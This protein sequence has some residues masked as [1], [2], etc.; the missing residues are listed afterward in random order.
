MRKSAK[1]A[2]LGLASAGFVAS[3]AIGGEEVMPENEKGFFD[4]IKS[5]IEVMSNEHEYTLAGHSSH[6]SH[7]SH[8]SHS[9]HRSY[10]A[11]PDIYKPD[12]VANAS[13][14]GVILASARNDRSTPNKSVLPS[15]LKSSKKLKVLPG[16]SEKFSKIVTEA[17]LALLA[18]GYDVG[19]IDGKLDAMAMSSIYKFQR[20][21]GMSATGRLTPETLDAL[22]VS[23]I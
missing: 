11:P 21:S 2:I 4:Q 23:A 17:Q 19:S 8:G 13:S 5:L 20:D 7:G 1:F 18:K 12:E 9:S 14:T 6:A 10:Y 15:I 16:N 22:N 3:P